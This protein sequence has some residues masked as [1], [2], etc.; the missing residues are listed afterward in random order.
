M[1]SCADPAYRRSRYV[2]KGQFWQYTLPAGA[3]EPMGQARHDVAPPLPMVP[4]EQVWQAVAPVDKENWPSPH[5]T[6]SRLSSYLPAS[7]ALH[8]SAVWAPRNGRTL[9]G[10][11]GLQSPIE[12]RP[13]TSEYVWN[14]QDVQALLPACAKCPRGQEKQSPEPR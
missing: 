14:G 1:Q 11:Q 12:P 4:F 9:P 7:Q 3:Y 10:G 8:A 6:H 13:G 5:A 2:C